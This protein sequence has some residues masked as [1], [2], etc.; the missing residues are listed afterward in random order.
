MRCDWYELDDGG[1]CVTMAI[2]ANDSLMRAD[3]IWFSDIWTNPMMVYPNTTSISFSICVLILTQKVCQCKCVSIYFT[4]ECT[5]ILFVH[6][7][8]NKIWNNFRTPTRTTWIKVPRQQFME[9]SNITINA[10]LL[11][12]KSWFDMYSRIFVQHLQKRR[13][14]KRRRRMLVI[15]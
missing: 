6:G 13:W 15:F 5:L 10:T 4:Y 1:N 3:W 9:F 7:T 8:A 2:T 14:R 11:L 12:C